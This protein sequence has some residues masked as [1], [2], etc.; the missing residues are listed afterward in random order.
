MKINMATLKEA[1]ADIG[2]KGRIFIPRT[3]IQVDVEILDYKETWGTPR[4]LVKPVS[5]KG[6]A[7]VQSVEILEQ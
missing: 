2:K 6:E 4:W 1:L 7:W 3:E 5:G